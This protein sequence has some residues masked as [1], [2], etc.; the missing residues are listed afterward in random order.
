M[1]YV[2]SIANESVVENNILSIPVELGYHVS[3]DITTRANTLKLKDTPEL[4]RTQ[5]GSTS[6]AWL[7]RW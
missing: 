1:V 2:A 6:R 3:F 5:R 4:H 7:I